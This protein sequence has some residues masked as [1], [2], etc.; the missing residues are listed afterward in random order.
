MGGSSR[1]GMLLAVA[2]VVGFVG[3]GLSGLRGAAIEALG[4]ALILAGAIAGGLAFWTN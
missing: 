1:R 3:L 2:L 4:L